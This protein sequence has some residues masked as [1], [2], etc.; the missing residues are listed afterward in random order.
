MPL[1][2][3][4]LS[5]AGFAA[6]CV[7]QTPPPP[8]PP[9]FSCP[10][11]PV[12]PAS[13]PLALH[14][15]AVPGG[16]LPGAIV[17]ATRTADAALFVGTQSG[18]VYAVSGGANTQVLDLSA[19]S[20]QAGG[21]QGLLGMTFSPD[22]AHLYVHYSATGSGAT[23][24]A[25]YP[26]SGG[27]GQTLTF[28]SQRV[29]LTFPQPQAN[30]NGGGLLFG[31][32]GDLYLA[33]GDG[34]NGNDNAPGYGG[35]HDAVAKGNGQSVTTLLGKI[36]RIN[37]ADP[38]PPG[39]GPGRDLSY[40]VP[41][42]NP[43]IGVATARE[44]IWSYGLRNPFRFSFDRTTGDLWIGDVG[45]GAR[46][47]VDFVSATDATHPGGTGANFGWNRCEG[48]IA[49]PEAAAPNSN[50]TPV[51]PPVF[52]IAHGSGGDC[53][54]I[55]GYVYRGAA[56]PSLQGQYVYSDN[57]NGLVRSLTPGG[58]GVSNRSLGVSASSP[59]SFGQDA[60][61]ELYVLSLSGGLFQLTP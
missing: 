46:E 2:V 18:H 50:G 53:A 60:S 20:S 17:M 22:G 1:L 37:P 8:P 7:P 47:E 16:N 39:G 3:V 40:S 28:G 5:I 54:I 30:H 23:T 51:V 45:Q 11:S 26:V 6:A 41:A 59:A 52:D 44:E 4:A 38:A 9:P 12:A 61:G 19:V 43:F 25:D 27:A 15:T 21:E 57:C 49:G 24:V 48:M 36:L 14:L 34:G 56:I 35:G 33:L 32:D 29:V 31:P 13:S 42:G 10:T 55:G 58:G